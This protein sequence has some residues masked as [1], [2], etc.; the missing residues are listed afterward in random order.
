MTAQVPDS[1]AE[2][3]ATRRAE[4]ALIFL[5]TAV[6]SIVGGA[7][8]LIIKVSFDSLTSGATDTLP[9]V[10]GAVIVATATRSVLLYN[11][12]VMAARFS[13]RIVADLRQ[14]AFA[15][16]MVQDYARLVADAPGAHISRLTNETN[17]IGTALQAGLNTALRDSLSVLVLVG[18]MFYLDWVMSAVILLVYPIAFLPIVKISERL[19]KVAKQTQTQLSGM[20]SLLAETFDAA[21]LIKSYRLESYASDKSS[22]KFEGVFR[23]GVKSARAKALVDPMLEALGGIAVAGVIGLAYWR[24]SSGQSTVGDFMGFTSALLMAAQ[25]IRALGNLPARLQQGLAAGDKYYALIDEVPSVIERPDSKSLALNGA[26]IAFDNVTFTYRALEPVPPTNRTSKA[27]RPASGH[28][29][30]ANDEKLRSDAADAHTAAPRPIRRAVPALR[31]VSVTIRGGQTV[32]LVGRSGG[33]KSTFLNL[34]PRLFD[35]DAG[36]IRI[37][38]QDIRDVTLGSLRDAIAVVSQDVTLFD[39]TIRANIALGRLDADETDIHE[40][41]RRAA[42]DA[43]IREQP[44]GYDTRV[45]SAGTRLS[46]GQKQRI[47][48]ARA[49]VKDAPILLLDEATS[50]LDAESERLVQDALADFS[51]SRTTLVIAHRLATVQ[52]ADLICV[53]DR[54]QI[55]ELGTHAELRAAGGIYAD[56]CRS[57]LLAAPDPAA[58]PGV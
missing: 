18:T 54:G 23:L 44:D 28:V 11:Q 31:D 38:G 40:A 49:F 33:G 7:Y 22:D 21:R 45:G 29:A 37:D 52:S 4:I 13:L 34:I 9:L 27:I 57:Q 20:T 25:P 3:L 51:Q 8:P 5:V 14:R 56:L 1:A 46:G 50:A 17:F 26:T 2:P 30:K 55:A 53:M 6:L 43:F 36:A 19:R 39:D 32:A 10:I 41:A 12:A 35:V 48:L 47:A 16:L 24:I 15:A 58:R 42:A